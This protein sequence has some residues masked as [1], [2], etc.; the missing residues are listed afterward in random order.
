MTMRLCAGWFSGRWTVAAIGSRVRPADCHLVAVDHYMPGH[1]GLA[2]LAQLRALPSPPPIVYVTGSEESRIAVAA[3]KAGAVD[4][5]VKTVGDDFFDLL[6]NVFRQTLAATTLRRE[7]EAAEMKLQASNEQLQAMLREV[8]HRVANSL[9]LVSAFVRMQAA[10][11][12]DPAAKLA[13]EDTQQRIAAIGQV[14]QRLYSSGDVD[15]VEMR[16]YLGALAEELEQ[17]W[18]TPASPRIVKIDA[19]PLRLK[20]DRAV[21]V[22]IIVTELVSNACKYAYPVGQAGE[23]RISLASEADDHF[24]LTVED[25]GCGIHPGEHPK[26]TGLGTT[27]IAAMAK[28]LQ[29]SVEMAEGRAGV[30]ATLRA[31]R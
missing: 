31:L 18:S 6:D 19:E 20:T 8:N 14:H 9:Q 5:V 4:Y 23:V 24:R 30:S 22:G 10:V 27:L 3:L 12:A 28:G 13:L 21:S 29:T 25:D 1:D 16:D 15:T 17:T 2:T 26:G 7:K 11:V